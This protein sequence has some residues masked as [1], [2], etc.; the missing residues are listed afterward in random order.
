MAIYGETGSGKTL[1]ARCIYDFVRKRKD[2]FRDN[3]LG[4]D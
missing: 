3:S 4:P 1:F 2:L